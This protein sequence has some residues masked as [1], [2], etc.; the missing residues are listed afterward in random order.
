MTKSEIKSEII[1]KVLA[2]MCG[3][4]E[5][6]V[7]NRPCDNGAYCDMCHTEGV[8]EAIQKAL[9]ENGLA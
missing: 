6:I 5:D 3:C 8:R 2:T 7:G 9:K 1:S 4:Y